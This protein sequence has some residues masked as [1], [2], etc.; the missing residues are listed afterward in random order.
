[1]KKLFLCVFAK[2]IRALFIRF[3][4]SYY[5][6]VYARIDFWIAGAVGKGNEFVDR[7]IAYMN[8]WKELTNTEKI[9]FKQDIEEMIRYR[10]DYSRFITICLKPA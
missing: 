3:D 10:R 1:M 7:Y 2:I 6:E 8:N 9:V 4:N 5:A